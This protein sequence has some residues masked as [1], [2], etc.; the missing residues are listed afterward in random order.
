MNP[1]LMTM[2]TDTPQLKGWE[3][4]AARREARKIER[5]RHAQLR[6]LLMAA[7][8]DACA[9]QYLAIN[10]RMIFG[11]KDA[12][13]IRLTGQHELAAVKVVGLFDDFMR[14]PISGK[15]EREDRRKLMR[16]VAEAICGASCALSTF[17]DREPRWL[18]ML[19]EQAA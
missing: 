2:F 5:E 6:R 18:A 11:I 9:R 16:R 1:S 17:R 3:A 14:L 13:A 8:H 4:T 12:D 10:E 15:A 7:Y 19:T